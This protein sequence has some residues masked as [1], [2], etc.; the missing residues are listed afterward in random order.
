MANSS[1]GESVVIYLDLVFLNNFVI[2]GLVMLA[3]G[4]SRKL[5][6]RWWRIA[7]SA[8]IGAS[9][10]L[11]MFIPNT[12]FLFV[13]WIKFLVSVL[14]VIT[15]FGCKSLQYVL[16]NLGV[17]YLINF[18]AAGGLFGIFYFFKSSP[19][20]LNG[21]GFTQAGNLLFNIKLSL[22]FL[23]IGVFLVLWFYKRVTQSVN[24]KKD[25]TDCFAEVDI[26][27][28]GQV[29]RCTG[30]IDTGN[31][32]VEPITRAP[33]MVME[34]SLWKD[35]FPQEWLAEIARERAEHVLSDSKWDAFP[36]RHRIRLV[37]YRGVNQ[38][39][40]FMLAVKPDKVVITYHDEQ[41]IPDKVL[42]GL[43]G[44][45][46][47]AEESYQA[48]I[49]PGLMAGSGTKVDEQKNAQEDIPC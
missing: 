11:M 27:W 44:G 47:H 25:L 23:L 4:W 5:P 45:R 34:V 22:L 30:L 41:F 20:V 42:I 10:V 8:F 49:H 2:D 38:G 13:F 33:V 36:W 19:D 12:A 28:D 43:D 6:G 15:A 21:I 26:T 7:A 29:L 46:L 9:Y 1:R 17:F 48:I 39:S 35:I 31:Q 3:T 40:R 32:L 14:M 16:R 37:P 24:K 18:V